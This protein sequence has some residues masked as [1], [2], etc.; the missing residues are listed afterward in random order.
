[1][2]F[3]TKS[4]SLPVDHQDREIKTKKLSQPKRKRSRQGYGEYLLY[5]GGTVGKISISAAAAALE[6]PYVYT[7]RTGARGKK[8]GVVFIVQN[9]LRSYR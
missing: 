3:L 7:C 9:T 8:E 4:D 5:F 2:L 6:S 1:M